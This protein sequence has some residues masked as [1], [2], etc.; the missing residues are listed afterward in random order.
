MQRT[1]QKHCSVCLGADTL[2][3][4]ADVFHKLHQDSTFKHKALLYETIL[5]V[6]TDGMFRKRDTQA[7]LLDFLHTM[8]LKDLQLYEDAYARLLVLK[9]S[10]PLLSLPHQAYINTELATTQYDLGKYNDALTGY[11]SVVSAPDYKEYPDLYPVLWIGIG[12][13]FQNREPPHHDSAI[14]YFKKAIELQLLSKDTLKLAQSYLNLGAAYYEDMEDSL[15]AHNWSLALQLAEQRNLTDMLDEVYYNMAQLYEETAPVLALRYYKQYAL[16]RDKIWNRDRLW[17]LA[18]QKRLYELKLSEDKIQLLK[19]EQLF[20]EMLLKQGRSERRSLIAVVTALIGIALLLAVL[21]RV[22]FSKNKLIKREKA[23]V[24]GLYATQNKLYSVV[25]HDLRAP[26]QSLGRT[27]AQ[28]NEAL[29]DSS[30]T[31]LQVLLNQN[32]KGIES[33]YR[34]LDNLLQW[35]MSQSENLVFEPQVHSLRRLVEQVCYNFENLFV[36]NNIRFRIVIAEQTLI[37]ADANTIKTVC[38]NLMDNSIRFSPEGSSI[39]WQQEESGS[40]EEVLVSLTDNGCGIPREE[41]SVLF[42]PKPS[43]HKGASLDGSGS[44]GLGLLI[45]KD[46]MLKNEGDIWIDPTYIEGARFYLRFKKA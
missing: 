9:R 24:D 14:H 39:T 10:W 43:T 29:K 13:C 30:K 7:Y 42:K 6:R 2:V 33:T 1:M 26:V 17:E 16:T 40:K 46:F 21:Y 15:A 31:Q 35:S 11:R 36:Q 18:E 25:A 41:A 38:R 44:S 12:L 27:N 4:E 19:N 23:K 37:Y 22:V 8:T 45:C 20:N 32:Q 34:L 28:I 5:K 3:P